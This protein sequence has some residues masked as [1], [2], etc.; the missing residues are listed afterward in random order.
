MTKVVVWERVVRVEVPGR[1]AAPGNSRKGA[2]ASF[3]LAR[4]GLG[5]AIQPAGAKAALRSQT[6]L[7][8]EETLWA[9]ELSFQMV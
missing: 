6:D 8:S 4:P 3:E 1:Q 9:K 2:A 7:R 5:P